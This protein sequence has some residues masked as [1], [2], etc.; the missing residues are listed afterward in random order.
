MF[1]DIQRPVVDRVRAGETEG[2]YCE[3]QGHDDAS[4]YGNHLVDD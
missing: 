3:E 4:R 2:S 1:A